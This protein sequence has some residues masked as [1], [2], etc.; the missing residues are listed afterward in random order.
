MSDFPCRRAHASSSG[1]LPIGRRQWSSGQTRTPT[2]SP[3]RSPCQCMLAPPRPPSPTQR[4][5]PTRA[6]NTACCGRHTIVHVR[7]ECPLGVCLAGLSNGSRGWRTASAM[8]PRRSR[9]QGACGR[10]ASRGRSSCS[11]TSAAMGT[12][13]RHP[14]CRTARL[15][16]PSPMVRSALAA[17]RQLARVESRSPPT[18]ASRMSYDICTDGVSRGTGTV[19]EP[20]FS[21]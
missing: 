15:G 12:K 5:S 6:R 19:T 4:R 10:S 2:S 20:G 11:T 9:S 21:G 17:A 8:R 13:S 1:T 18:S 16:W 7:R 3:S 14:I